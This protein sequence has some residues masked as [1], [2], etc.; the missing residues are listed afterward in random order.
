MKLTALTLASIVLLG[1]A[2]VASAPAP[3]IAAGPAPTCIHLPATPAR[4]GF[5]VWTEARNDCAA[6]T[7]LWLVRHESGSGSGRHSSTEA[8]LMPG[9]SGR[10]DRQ[11]RGGG[12]QTWS[13]VQF[14]PNMAF[15]LS[16]PQVAISC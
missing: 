9:T 13:A 1:G 16:T 12:D 14:D 3:R 2:A 15:N 4:D 8:V 7:T 10:I 11:C 5:R 6:P